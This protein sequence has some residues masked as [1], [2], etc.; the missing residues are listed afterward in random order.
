MTPSNPPPPPSWAPRPGPKR[1]NFTPGHRYRARCT[2]QAL[3]DSFTEGEVMTFDRSAY[4]R[5]DGIMGY[6]FTQPG[7]EGLRLFD[8]YDEDDT[9]DTRMRHFQEVSEDPPVSPPS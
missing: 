7:R 2:F 5:Y 6:F 4:S 8:L 1:F 3:R 9:D